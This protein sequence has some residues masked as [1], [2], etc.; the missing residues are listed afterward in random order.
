MAEP[1][2]ADYIIVGAGSAGCVLANRL[3]ADGRT[4]VLLL[5]AGGDDRPLKEPSQFLS[6]LMI[7]VPVGYT[8]TLKDPKV[9]WLYLTDPDPGTGGRQH[10]WPRGK[11]LGG[12]SSIKGRIEDA[13]AFIAARERP[14]ALYCF[15]SDKAQQQRVLDGALSGGVTLNGPCC[16]SRRKT[17]PSAASARAGSA[18]I[19]A[20]NASAG[21]AMPVPCTRSASSMRSSGSDRPGVSSPARP[22]DS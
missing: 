10:V 20:W 5:E 19:T 1:I 2:E 4:K 14:L 11:V 12:S 7:H 16:M 15:S 3:T 9:N 18:P 17:S 22:A 6:N 21:S 8:H 13:I